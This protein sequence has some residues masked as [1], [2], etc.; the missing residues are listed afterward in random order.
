MNFMSEPT[1]ALSRLGVRSQTVVPKAVR[2]A[3]GLKPGDRV[4]FRIEQ[5]R[6]ELIK[7]GA[8]ADNPFATFREWAG[9]ADSQGY[10][11]L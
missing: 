1:L 8:G 4:G 10:S 5:G 2:Q 6:V 7:L 11:G 9:D 3:L